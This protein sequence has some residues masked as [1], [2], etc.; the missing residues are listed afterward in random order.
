[1]RTLESMVDPDIEQAISIIATRNGAALAACDSM[2]DFARALTK[3][4]GGRTLGVNP[5]A[6]T[7][8]LGLYTRSY[9]TYCAAVELAR[10]GFGPQAAMLNRSLFEY[11]IDAHWVA[12]EPQAAESLIRDHHTHGRML[13]AD[14]VRKY[15]TFFSAIELPQF[16]GAE[17]S[18]LDGL[19]GR[20]GTSSWTRLSPHKR[21]ERIEHFW[22]NPDDVEALRFYRDIAHRENNQLLHPSAQSLATGLGRDETGIT[23]EMGP[24]FEM[25]DRALYG[26]FWIFSQTVGLV[27]AHFDF[28][29]DDE[30][31]ASVFA[32]DPAFRASE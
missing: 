32:M 5:V 31:R 21:V 14:A 26:S 28:D 25:L 4:W 1:V 23:L 9:S 11:M 19:F 22:S 20:H 13:L 10:V 12:A 15:P 7:L 27:L 2:R 3:P 29:V 30:T 8:I 24:G 16:D 18:R 17:R 6:D